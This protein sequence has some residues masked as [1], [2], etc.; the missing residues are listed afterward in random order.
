M[1]QDRMVLGR[2]MD[3]LAWAD[4]RVLQA[5]MAAES[6]P[7]TTVTLLA[8]LAAAEHIWYARLTGT[9]PAHPVWPT[10]SI[11]EAARLSRETVDGF[12]TL[13]ESMHPEDLHRDISYANSTGTSFTTSALDILIHVCL[14]GAYHRGQIAT[15]VRQ[16]GG[17]PVSTDYIQFIRDPAAVAPPR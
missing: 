16:A 15:T 10:L 17:V 13:L 14:H 1:S 5:L 12:R 3:H 4:Q 2:M 6:V 7:S 8:H 11:A 9:G